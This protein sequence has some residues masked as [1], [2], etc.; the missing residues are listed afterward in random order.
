VD[1]E[2]AAACAYVVSDA[3]DL[4]QRDFRGETVLLRCDLNVPLRSA[5][6]SARPTVEDDTRARLSLPTIDALVAG[7]ARVAVLSHLGRP[8][9]D[10]QSPAE[11]RAAWSLAPVADFFARERPGAFRGFVG[12][13]VGPEVSTA[14]R[15]L[16]GGQFVLL[17]NTR[18]HPG[19]AA[20]DPAFAEELVASAGAT[21]FVLDAFGAAHRDH[22][23]VTGVAAA[24]GRARGAGAGGPPCVLPGLLFRRE[25]EFLTRAVWSP[26]RPFCCVVGGAK[27]ADKIGVL[28]ALVET[29]DCIL[30]GGRMAFTFLAAQ[31]IHVGATSVEEGKL[32][33]AREV[34]EAARRRG[35]RLLLPV[36]VTVGDTLDP[37][38]S[39][40]AVPL[41]V[42]CCTPDAPCIAPGTYGG[43]LGPETARQYASS[44]GHCRTIFW[45]G[46]MGKFEV[47]EYGAG[48]AAV[49]GAVAAARGARGAVTIVGGGDSVAAVDRAGRAGDFSHVSTG[50]GAGLELIE[51]R[52]MP[53]VRAVHRWR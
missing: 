2:L 52:H 6:G 51:G 49:L 17:E 22:A 13:C 34:I 18:F 33:V 53:G 39:T 8:D 35:V 4:A 32:G 38:A 45:N 44:L 25:V 30:L 19:D 27:V 47:P 9:P 36:D 29:A 43:D 14:V 16:E 10:A 31:G 50:G 37:G 5:G 28:K 40:R 15:A 11:M 26:E 12:D 21:V 23:S 46:P 42:G 24:L 41:A 7:G 1:P 20:N 48:T 3:A